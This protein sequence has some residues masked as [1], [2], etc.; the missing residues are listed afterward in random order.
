[1][2]SASNIILKRTSFVQTFCAPKNWTLHIVKSIFPFRHEQIAYSDTVECHLKNRVIRIN[3]VFASKIRISHDKQSFAFGYLHYSEYYVKHRSIRAYHVEQ[4]LNKI[5][6][7]LSNI[8]QRKT[9]LEHSTGAH[10]RRSCGTC[11]T[12][13]L[14]DY[15]T[16]KM[17]VDNRYLIQKLIIILPKYVRLPFGAVRAHDSFNECCNSPSSV[18]TRAS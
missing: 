11:S 17:S 9:E 6:R 16:A 4:T 5:A 13:V 7:S 15:L 2:F 10:L 3:N 8:Q 18:Q 1:M 12:F 14:Y